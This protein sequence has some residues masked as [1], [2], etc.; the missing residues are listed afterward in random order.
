MKLAVLTSFPSTIN[1]NSKR[2][3]N[4]L[5]VSNFDPMNFEY[6]AKVFNA[7]VCNCK[8]IYSMLISVKAKTPNSLKKLV[9]DLKLSN[10]QK[11]FSVPY[12]IASEAYVWSFQYRMLNFILFTNDK[13]FKIGLSVSDKCSFCGTCSEDLYHLFF[14]CSTAQ[15]FWNRFTVWW[16]D[17]GGENLSLTLKD[18]IIGF[19]HRTDVLNYLIILGKITIW[20]SRKNKISPNFRLFLHKVEAKQEAEKIIAL[21]NRKLREFYKRWELL[22]FV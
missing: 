10:P 11:F 20:E 17:L 21:K 12:R 16:S 8:Q 13:L 2:P 5:T 15:A 3:G 1:M 4:L 19:L 9:A 14:Y 7:Y 6:N 22:L 18:I